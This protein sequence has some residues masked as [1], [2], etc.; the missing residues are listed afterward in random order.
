MLLQGNLSSPRKATDQDSYIYFFLLFFFNSMKKTYLIPAVLVGV[1]AIGASAFA[2]ST[3]TGS[4]S[5]RHAHSFSGMTASG[6]EMPKF[7]AFAFS[8]MTDAEKT[9]LKTF[10]EAEKTEREQA[11]K[12]SDTDKAALETLRNTQEKE[13]QALR[14]TQQK[15]RRALLATK[16]V[17]VV[18]EDLQAQ[19]KTIMEK[20]KPTTSDKKGFGPG[21]NG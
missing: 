4:M 3:S 10:R 5:T 9:T 16:G 14:E 11:A 18:S 2:A 17:T 6:R 8:G 12:L 19:V 7:E 20:Y 13:I 21:R 1:A 15:A